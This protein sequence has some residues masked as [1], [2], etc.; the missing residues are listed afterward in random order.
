MNIKEALIVKV[1]LLKL[2]LGFWVPSYL[3]QKL[4]CFI[5]VKKEDNS[6]K[7]VE[8][9]KVFNSKK[10]KKRQTILYKDKKDAWATNY[11]SINGLYGSFV[12]VPVFDLFIL[13]VFAWFTLLVPNLSTLSI[14]TRLLPGLSAP[15]AS[16]KFIILMASLSA[17]FV[18]NRFAV[19]IFACNAEVTWP[20]N[21]I[22]FRLKS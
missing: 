5:E 21:H 1:N 20:I 22:H 3:K 8:E 2:Y 10:E 17:L 11:F 9:S 15:S 18:A 4:F 19:L 7:I 6:Q 14:S 16:A 13:S 12:S